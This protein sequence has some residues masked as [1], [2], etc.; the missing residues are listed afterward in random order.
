M[1]YAAFLLPHLSFD[2]QIL[3]WSPV[4]FVGEF[5]QL[6]PAFIADSTVSEVFHSLLDLPCLSAT[7]QAQHLLSPHSMTFDPGLYPNYAKCLAA[8][9]DST[10]KL[11]FG[12]FLR[13]ENGK[14]DTIDRLGNIHH[15]LLDFVGHE[16]VKGVSRV[17]PL[18][19]KYVG[20]G[21]GV[22]ALFEYFT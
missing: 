17:A 9:Q 1:L 19:L 16:R 12:H 14:G 18:L 13:S 8:F 15:L 20:L 2:A 4:T 11:M 22:G 6:L 5:I 7:L 21:K 3:A 10:Y